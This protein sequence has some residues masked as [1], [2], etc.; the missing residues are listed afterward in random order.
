MRQEVQRLY[1]RCSKAIHQE[2]VIKNADYSD[3]RFI[4]EQIGRSLELTAKL[5]IVF[6]CSPHV[7]HPAD[8]PQTF[9]WF[10]S[11]NESWQA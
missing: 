9:G 5:C 11:L 2:F 7:L 1:S 6:N 10:Q 3:H 4:L 8:K